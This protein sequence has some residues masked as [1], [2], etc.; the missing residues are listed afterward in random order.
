[1]APVTKPSSSSIDEDQH[2]S[3][4]PIYKDNDSEK[5]TSVVVGKFLLSNQTPIAQNRPPRLCNILLFLASVLATSSL[6]AAVF[7]SFSVT[8]SNEERKF[9]PLNASLSKEESFPSYQSCGHSP[10]EAR[11]KGC[12]FDLMLSTW[13]PPSCADN[14][15]METYL[16][17][18]KYH[19]FR[20]ENRTEP[21]SE[22]EAR[23]GEY[24]V[25]W[26]EGEFHLA[27]CV[28]LMD[29]QIRSY[30]TARPVEVGIF[31]HGHT[32]HCV[33]LTLGLEGEVRN[34]TTRL[35]A[36]FGGCGFPRGR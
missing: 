29:M 26:T 34:R 14:A 27:H 9:Y 17:Q 32:M 31:N 20:D 35:H 36:L 7:S 13:I 1:M 24:K 12:T 16:S 25:I 33:N 8:S 18:G 22:K 4:L 30:K 19:Y 11:A 6:L 3:L 2:E 21:M 23:K 28:Y 15:M 10:T 5:R